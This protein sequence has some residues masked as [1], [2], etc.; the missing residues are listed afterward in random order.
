LKDD[1]NDDDAIL[2]GCGSNRFCVLVATFG[3]FNTKPFSIMQ[4]ISIAK[5]SKNATTTIFHV[6]CILQNKPQTPSPKQTWTIKSPIFR[7][8]KLNY[9]GSLLVC[10]PCIPQFDFGTSWIM[11]CTWSAVTPI[12]SKDRVI[13][14][15]NMAFWS[16]VFPA[17]VS[18]MTTGTRF[19][20][21][22]QTARSIIADCMF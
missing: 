6:S 7:K 19:H 8:E 13:P 5:N 12:S 11:I 22:S 16:S 15:I 14:L 17:Q 21:P 18:I 20:L 9:G 3:N 2:F 4:P 1:D 10:S